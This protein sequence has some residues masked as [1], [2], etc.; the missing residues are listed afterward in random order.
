MLC[1]G[2]PFPVKKKSLKSLQ[3]GLSTNH[4][5]GN[6]TIVHMLPYPHILLKSIV[7]IKIRKKFTDLLIRSNSAV[8][9]L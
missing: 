7:T 5:V 2:I 6:I 3:N 9:Y 8:L 1:S 4:T